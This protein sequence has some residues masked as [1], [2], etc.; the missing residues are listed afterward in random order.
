MGYRQRNS[1]D[2]PEHSEA[3][4]NMAA[5]IKKHKYTAISTSE[6]SAEQDH[7]TTIKKNKL[8]QLLKDFNVVFDG[9]LGLYP[10]E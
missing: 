7:M 2:E 5:K 4:A 1:F 6:V 3:F 10:H 8:E 9:K